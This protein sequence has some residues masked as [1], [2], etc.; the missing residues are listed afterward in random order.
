MNILD[1][2]IAKKLAGGGG[3]SG[4][5][6]Y[7][8]LS[9][10][11]KINDTTLSGNK[12]SANLGL[13]SEIN[14][15]SK[16]ASDLVDDTNQDN[17]FVT[18]TEKNTWNAKQNAIDADHKI[19]ADYVDDSTSTN[20]FVT[21]TDKEAWN[22]KQN[23]ID[24][25][26]KLSSDLVDD[27][28][29][30]NKFVTST[31]KNTW[32]AKQNAIDSDHKLSSSLVSFTT[33]E[34]AALASGIDSSKVDQISTN[35]TNILYGLDNG[36]KNILPITLDIIKDANWSATWDGNKTTI[37]G[38]TFTVNPDGT[39]LA[40]GTLL[41]ESAVLRL[42]WNKPLDYVGVGNVLSGCPSGGGSSSAYQV[43]INR[44][45]TFE[46]IA[47]DMGNGATIAQPSTSGYI[48]SYINITSSVTNKLFKPMVCTANVWAQSHKYVPYS[49]NNSSLTSLAIYN[50]ANGVKNLFNIFD[51]TENNSSSSTI[52]RT[53]HADGHVTVSNNGQNSSTVVLAYSMYIKAGTYAF[54]GCPTGGSDDSYFLDIRTENGSFI[55]G[56]TVDYG[57]GGTAIIPTTG[58]YQ[59][60]IRIAANAS[61]SNKDFYLM[62]CDPAVFNADSSYQP[63]AKSNSE[64]TSLEA[65]DRAALAEVVDS[66]KKQLLQFY[67]D[68]TE[69]LT[70]TVQSDGYTVRIT[71]GGET[72]NTV[73]Y[74]E[75]VIEVTGEYALKVEMS[76]T[77]TCYLQDVT[78]TTTVDTFA[79]SDVRFFTLTAGHRYRIHT[80]R[81]GA[82]Y[83]ATV[84]V[85]LCSKAAYEISN[86]LLPYFADR[87]P[88][89]K[90][91]TVKSGSLDDVAVNTYAFYHADVTG[92]PETGKYAF[93]RTDVLDSNTAI[94]HLTYASDPFGKSYVR[95]KS[96][97]TWR[98]WLQTTNA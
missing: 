62:L 32:N 24:N 97:G 80:Y 84:S 98:S 25:S 96:G 13:Q 66:G 74:A 88:A 31:E 78:T 69:L 11:P 37:N 30:T 63:Y 33:A 40:D 8:D 17:K 38:I 29:H 35:Q 44:M 51:A 81:A 41:S 21:A 83:D 71:G 20:K 27:A 92:K 64:L 65:E 70:A 26:H 56:V 57:S 72:G 45:D 19:N 10:L 16:L 93:V 68:S 59:F 79:Y 4:T 54:N 6:N 67:D 34:A 94:Q 3:G 36:V 90:T 23:A 53:I 7:N 87:A 82:N 75:T 50:N 28:N 39:I 18:S 58:K 86:K 89:L 2:A 47:N 14:S 55:P 49:L 1:I 85:L 42:F 60:F 43:L 91:M 95:V 15:D 5:D 77:G 9:N 76:S 46:N 73:S 22:A 12:T 48:Y 52:T 61:F